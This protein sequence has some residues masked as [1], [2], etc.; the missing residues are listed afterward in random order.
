MLGVCDAHGGF[1]ERADQD[2]GERTRGLRRQ[3]A[4]LD[5]RA[6]ELLGRSQ[7]VA[8]GDLAEAGP[9][10]HAGCVEQHQLAHLWFGGDLE[11]RVGGDMQSISGRARAGAR[12]GH[13]QPFQD[14][15]LDGLEHRE[16]QRRLV[17]VLVVHRAA[18]H[19]GRAGDLGGRDGGIA[20]GAPQLP[21]GGEERLLGR[22]GSFC[23]GATHLSA[24]CWYVT[25]NL[26]ANKYG[27][28]HA[29]CHDQQRSDPL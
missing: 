4:R 28:S 26:H 8:V 9:A 18:R 12:D 16:E 3:L 5:R 15:G 1:V 22:G 21:S 14:V 23:L 2:R 7:P 25:C 17:G 10:E 29:Q 24:A 27:G 13:R 6:Q 11:P 19:T 20:T